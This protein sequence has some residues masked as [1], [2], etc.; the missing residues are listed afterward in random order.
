[1]NYLRLFF[2]FLCALLLTGCSY[3]V[4][5][6]DYKRNINDEPLGQK[7]VGKYFITKVEMYAT[8]QGSRELHVVPYISIQGTYRPEGG[9]DYKP[10]PYKYL[11][12]EGT[13]FKIT[14]LHVRSSHLCQASS[15]DKVANFKAEF[16]PCDQEPFTGDATYLFA[17]PFDSLKPDLNFIDEIE[18][19]EECVLNN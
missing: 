7:I 11:L 17:W 3:F 1:M 19:D 8:H 2:G 9:F 14:E 12:K 13:I 15:S 4:H 6:A 5:M 18:I 10:A 16:Y